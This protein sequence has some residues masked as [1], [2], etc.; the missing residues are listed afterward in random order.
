MAKHVVAANFHVVID[1]GPDKPG[2]K[3]EFKKG[4][5]LEEKDLP[6]G[7]TFAD[8]IGKGLATASRDPLDHDG[9]GRKGGS[10]PKAS[11]NSA[12]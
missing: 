9:D 7:H 6:D 3:V 8:W 5:V 1:Q 2:R 12:A 10:L 11:T 4:Q